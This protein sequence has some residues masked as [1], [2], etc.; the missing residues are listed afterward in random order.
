MLNKKD[1]LKVHVFMF[2]V[3]IILYML[4]QILIW[5]SCVCVLNSLAVG[6]KEIDYELKALNSYTRLCEVYHGTPIVKRS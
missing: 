5:C 2:C 3:S 6:I 4:N 1:L